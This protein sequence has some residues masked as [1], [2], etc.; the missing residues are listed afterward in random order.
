V[1]MAKAGPRRR[2]QMLAGL[3]TLHQLLEEV[4]DAEVM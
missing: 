4:A 2:E 1:A 3:A